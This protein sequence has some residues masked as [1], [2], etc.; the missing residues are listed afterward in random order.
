MKFVSGS[1]IVQKSIKI[2][3]NGEIL[4]ELMLPRSSTCT[5]T[6]Q[7]SRFFVNQRQFTSTM[8][9]VLESETLWKSFDSI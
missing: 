2:Q 8:K 7:I 3:F 5:I 6:L 4:S 9:H 1:E